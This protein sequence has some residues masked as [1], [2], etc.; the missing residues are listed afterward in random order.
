MV[1]DAHAHRACVVR[2]I[3]AKLWHVAEWSGT[4]L[5]DI[6]HGGYGHVLLR[7]HTS[8]SSCWART[9]SDFLMSGNVGSSHESR[10]P[11]GE[12][13]LPCMTS[14]EVTGT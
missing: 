9:D 1:C 8:A 5:G 3:R 4:W 7:S 10:P 12:R 13:W 6:C 14:D 11:T 2:N